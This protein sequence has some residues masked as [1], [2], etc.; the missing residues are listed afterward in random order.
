[1]VAESDDT[2]MLRL[3]TRDTDALAFM[4]E[5]VV[6]DELNHGT[7]QHYMLLP[8][9]YENFYAH[10]DEAPPRSFEIGYV[11]SAVTLRKNVGYGI[12]FAIADCLIVLTFL[13]LT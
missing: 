11:D 5:V 9:V 8:N 6:K 4:P 10:Q 13:Y 7:L 12:A 2:A 1:M 3:L